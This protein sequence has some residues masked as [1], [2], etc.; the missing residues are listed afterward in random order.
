MKKV[1]ITETEITK[2]TKMVRKEAGGI[3]INERNCFDDE[4]THRAI[5][6]S[7]ALKTVPNDRRRHNYVLTVCFYSLLEEF[8]T[9]AFMHYSNKSDALKVYKNITRWPNTGCQYNIE[10]FIRDVVSKTI[11]PLWKY[12]ICLGLA[13][14]KGI[15][16]FSSTNKAIINVAYKDGEYHDVFNLNNVYI[17]KEEK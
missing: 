14:P 13:G 10:H 3:I 15:K 17:S 5:D 7:L 9:F 11:D 12:H 8:A 4:F 1:I 6:V 16:A 2:I